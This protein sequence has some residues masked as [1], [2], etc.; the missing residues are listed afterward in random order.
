MSNSASQPAGAHPSRGQMLR[1]LYSPEKGMIACVLLQAAFQ[2]DREPCHFF[3][4]GDWEVGFPDASFGFV[5][6]SREAWQ[7]LGMMTR[8]ERIAAYLD[9]RQAEA[10]Q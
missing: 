8:E 1:S 2:G 6:L 4:A 5:E 10:S 3:G 9:A 7:R